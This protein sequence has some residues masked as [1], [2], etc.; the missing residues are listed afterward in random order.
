LNSNS[1]FLDTTASRVKE[2]EWFKEYY[3]N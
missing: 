3:A 1:C 2:L